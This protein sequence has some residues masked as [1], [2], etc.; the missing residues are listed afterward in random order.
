MKSVKGFTL[1]ELMI[2]IA[3]LALVTVIG[4]PAFSGIFERSRADSDLSDLLRAFSLARLEAINH[5]EDVNVSA[6]TDD[7]WTQDLE[8]VRDGTVIRRYA[9]LPSGATITATG[10]VD[11]IVFDSLGGLKTPAN[12][13]VFNYT[14]GDSTKSMVVCPTGRILTG[15]SCI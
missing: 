14:R 9:G 15:A 12:S 2:A 13:V 8:I 6:L 3:V 1:I 5:S 7:D 11:T 4:F 10:D